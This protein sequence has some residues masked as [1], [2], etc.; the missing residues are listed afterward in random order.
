M[1]TQFDIFSFFLITFLFHV[2]LGN[3]IFLFLSHFF[4]FPFSKQH[5]KSNTNNHNSIICRISEVQRSAWFLAIHKSILSVTID[6]FRYYL[7]NQWFVFGRLFLWELN[8]KRNFH[9]MVWIVTLMKMHLLSDS[10]N[11]FMEYQTSAFGG[12]LFGWEINISKPQLSCLMVIMYCKTW[13]CMT[14]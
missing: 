4:N 5:K 3:S 12:I 1:A 6:T 10:L 14:I 13:N 2:D 9:E 7:A 11:Y 8:C